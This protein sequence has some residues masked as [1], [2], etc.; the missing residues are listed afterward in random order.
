M[1]ISELRVRAAAAPVDSAAAL[2]DADEADAR[3]LGQHHCLPSQLI[4]SNLPAASDAVEDAPLAE[5]CAEPE[6]DDEP[7]EAAELPV[8]SALL[9]A[10]VDAPVVVAVLA[11]AT[12]VGV[13]PEV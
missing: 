6:C 7:D 10:G 2:E 1:S 13:A 8:L 9:S 3:S 12:P 5:L 4:V 11:V